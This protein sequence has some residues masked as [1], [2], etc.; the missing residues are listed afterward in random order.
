MPDVTAQESETLQAIAR[1]LDAEAGL[2]R[3]VF[4]F[5]YAIVPMVNVDLLALAEGRF[6]LAWREDEF[7]RGWHIPG[8]IFR[9]GETIGQRIEATA[10]DELGAAV[11]ASGTPAAIVQMFGDRGHN[12]SFL[13]PCR[14]NPGSAPLSRLAGDG[15]AVRAGDLRWFAAIPP[16]LY[17]A[18]DLYADLILDLAAGRMI[19]APAMLSRWDP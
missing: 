14:L 10:R 16:D 15:E 9:R 17:P 19:E 6:L 11:R 3:P 1:R 13:Y 5:A 2:P 4:D 18:H 12:I 8:G 7:G